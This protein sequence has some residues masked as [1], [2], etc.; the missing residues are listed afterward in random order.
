MRASSRFWQNGTNANARC[1]QPR[2]SLPLLVR[3]AASCQSAVQTPV[4]TLSILDKACSLV[5]S[6]CVLCA[7]GPMQDT[8]SQAVIAASRKQAAFQQTSLQLRS[9]LKFAV[10][11][12]A[13]LKN[14]AHPVSIELMTCGS[15]ILSLG[16]FQC[17]SNILHDM[18]F[19]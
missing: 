1:E 4:L 11:F 18:F 3:I 12:H 7:V 5:C 8:S 15:H 6:L 2:Q 14:N 17:C 10:I 13:R 16:L 19:V 9:Q